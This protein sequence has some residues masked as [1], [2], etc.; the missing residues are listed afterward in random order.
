[1]AARV[2]Q[3]AIPFLPASLL[4]LASCY[5][6]PPS[7]PVDYIGG[8]T[9]PGWPPLAVYHV[10]PFHAANRLFQRLFILEAGPA[11]GDAPCM[12]REAFTRVDAAEIEAL[13]EA[14]EREALRDSGSEP[15][16]ERGRRLLEIDLRSA[17]EFLRERSQGADLGLA[18][19]LE[20]L[21]AA[22]RS[23]AL[24]ASSPAIPPP[25]PGAL[26]RDAFTKT[27]PDHPLPARSGLEAWAMAKGEDGKPGPVRL[28]HFHRARWIAGQDPWEEVPPDRAI[29]LCS[30]ATPAGE[31]K[32]GTI[33]SL[34]GKCH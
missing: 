11:G 27:P 32:H 21:L 10:D 34:C 14:V 25:P 15:L 33:A 30:S 28:F 22:V 16:A 17:A 5:E 29:V 2:F 24:A 6:I 18:R 23:S 3:H 4:F 31:D 9:E 8:P 13:A 1:M 19:A 20:P 7:I 26:I 12:P